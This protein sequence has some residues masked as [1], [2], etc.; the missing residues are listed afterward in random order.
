MQWVGVVGLVFLSILSWDR[1]RDWTDDL[2]IWRAAVAHAPLKPRALINL[3]RAYDR[4]G[5]LEAAASAYQAALGQSFD[6]RRSLYTQKFS[7][8]A[9]QS[10][11]ARILVMYLQP[12]AAL[13]LTETVLEEW[14]TFP[15]GL[16]NHGVALEA[17]G[18]CDEATAAYAQARALDPNIPERRC[19]H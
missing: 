8:A 18:R 7:R 2:T 11:L 5:D 10:N 13:S 4:N 17:L 14:P 15:P 3:G 9:S 16:F 12:A 1:S 6:E 19:E